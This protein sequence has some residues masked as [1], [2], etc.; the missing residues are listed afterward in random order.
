MMKKLL[1]I[2]FLC[3]L[4]SKLSAPP[5]RCLPIM[6]GESINPYDNLLH[7]FQFVESNFDTDTI[8][9]LGYGGILQIGQEMIDEAN[10][11]CKITK[12][13]VRFMLIDRIDSARS[14]RIWYIVNDYW[15]PS[16][17]IEKACEIW[18]PLASE[19]YY[20]KITK[21]LENQKM[22]LSL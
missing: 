16:Y 18:N 3:S 11:I 10:R 20:K 9:S 2:I 19:N 15:N 5:D 12:N 4:I 13:P 8:N 6:K 1:L 17:D 22:L 14:V 7:A 21:Y